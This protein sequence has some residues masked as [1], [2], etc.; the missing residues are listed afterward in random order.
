MAVMSGEDID[1]LIKAA[2]RVATAL[3]RLALRLPTSRS[4]PMTI[5]AAEAAGF[6]AYPVTAL[7]EMDIAARRITTGK[8]G[9]TP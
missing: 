4:D 1:R 7:A 9:P 2:E 5:L 6:A 3:E 8:P